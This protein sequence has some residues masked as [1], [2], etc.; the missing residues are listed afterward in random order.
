MSQDKIS[1]TL[2]NREV[3]GKTVKHLRTQGI[4]PAVIHDHGK[5]S[6]NVQGD[7]VAM[8]KVWRQAGKHHPVE[9]DAAG[10]KFT[11]IIKS[12]T[13]D[14]R[15]QQLTHIVFNAVSATEQV[16]AEVPVRPKYDEGNESSPAER[17]GLLVLSQL[18]TV[19]ISAIAS[20]LPDFLEYN[21]ELLKEVGDH[22]TVA[23]LVV[24]V[25]VEIKTEA[26]HALATV[27][28]PS[29]LQAANEAVGGEP[30]QDAA[31]V[32]ADQGSAGDQADQDAEDKP[33]GQKQEPKGE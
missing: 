28:E 7:F 19:S 2:S 3:T 13:F 23:D 18:D 20:K 24:P 11:T 25:G 22:V 6:I 32:S 33:G 17:Q 31:D 14:P 30:D 12:A 27:Y 26:E 4:V 8:T 9:L 10:K 29:A 15:K 16:E 1:L 5:D 21:A